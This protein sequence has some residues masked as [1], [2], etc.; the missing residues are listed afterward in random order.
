M[1]LSEPRPKWWVLYGLL[2]L[3]VAGLA[4]VHRLGLPATAETSIQ[5]LIVAVF[6][7]LIGLW[8]SANTG[9]LL[10]ADDA[11]PAAGSPSPAHAVRSEPQAEAAK[12][13]AA[14][15]P[16]PADDPTPV[17]TSPSKPA[18][19]PAGPPIAGSVLE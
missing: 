4:A 5:G 12:D 16:K 8:L 10:R 15:R 7:G 14:T 9:A 17:K 18:S 6:F 19:A 13:A 3:A 1:T 11:P 2:A